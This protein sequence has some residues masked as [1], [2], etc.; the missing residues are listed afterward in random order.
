M[1]LINIVDKL[2]LIYHN[3]GFGLIFISTLIETTP[4][5]WAVPGGTVVAMGGFFA[6]TSDISLVTV[7]ISGT[8]GMFAT[9]LIAYSLGRKTGVAIAAKIG[10]E[11]NFEKAK[12]LL[13]DHGPSILST[14]LLANLTRFW[15]AYVAGAEKINIIKFSFYGVASS[16]T[17]SSFLATLG[18]LAGTER[19][20]LEKALGKIGILSWSLLIVAVVVMFIRVKQDYKKY[21]QKQK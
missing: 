14:S 19:S 6:R 1:D 3:W 15:I 9:F 21:N 16:L 7:I 11:K 10:Q 13:R 20:S 12:R 8:L 17:W 18:Y 2:G 5:G 4:L